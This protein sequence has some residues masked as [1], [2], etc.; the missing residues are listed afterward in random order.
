MVLLEP[1]VTST[2]PQCQ[3]CPSPNVQDR[4]DGIIL[5]ITCIDWCYF[6]VVLAKPQLL[7]LNSRFPS[8][9]GCESSK[10]LS[11]SQ[12]FAITGLRKTRLDESCDWSTLSGGYRLFRRDRQL[13]L[14]LYRVCCSSWTPTNL[15]VGLDGI[16]QRIL[17]E[18]ADVI[19]KALPLIFEWSWESGEVPD[20]WNLVNIALIFK[21]GKKEDPRNYRPVS[22]TSVPGKVVEMFILGSIEKHLKDNAVIGHSQHSFMR[23]RSCLL[24]LL[25]FYDKEKGKPVDVIFLEFGK[26]FHTVS[27]RILL[28]KKSSTQLDKHIMW[29]A[30]NWLMDGGQKS[31]TSSTLPLFFSVVEHHKAT[32]ELEENMNQYTVLCMSCC[33]EYLLVDHIDMIQHP[34]A[35]TPHGSPKSKVE[36]NEKPVGADDS[37]SLI[38][39]GGRKPVESDGLLIS[40][41]CCFSGSDQRFLVSSYPKICIPRSRLMW[42]NMNKNQ[43]IGCPSAFNISLVESEGIVKKSSRKDFE[44][45]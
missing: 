45:K 36:G 26:G 5:L 24:N 8:E 3:L 19:T 21:K 12:R 28:D 11:Q 37:P 23:G 33:P 31:I 25:S 34:G 42:P 30:S 27:H 14:K 29:W 41:F 35:Q 32:M 44:S 6:Q 1:A 43:T 9:S 2:V 18:L 4:Q 7:F 10:A 38:E 13:T 40:R 16:H 22:L 39:S 20:D 15:W 17:K